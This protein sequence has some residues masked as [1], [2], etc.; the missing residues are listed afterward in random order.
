MKYFPWLACERTNTLLIL[1]ER[2]PDS[3]V[4][5]TTRVYSEFSPLC[6]VSRD[7]GA[8]QGRRNTQILREHSRLRQVRPV[9]LPCLCVRLC[10]I[11]I[12]SVSFRS[13]WWSG[14]GGDQVTVVIRPQWWSGHSGDQVTVV[15]RPQ[16]CSGTGGAQATVV[17]KS[18]WLSG[19]GGDQVT[20]IVRPRWW[21]GHGVVLPSRC[22]R[23]TPL[24]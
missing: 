22:A 19:H 24:P 3:Q 4:H 6:H 12:R 15:V 18:R 1:T 7:V 8:S 21:S 2:Q 23:D 20:V 13:Y 10:E 14:Y 5:Y 11:R 17:I 16:W 9:L